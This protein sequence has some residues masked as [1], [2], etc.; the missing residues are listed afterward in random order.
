M[1]GVVGGRVGGR[2]RIGVLKLQRW[3]S[4]GLCEAVMGAK[5]LMTQTSEWTEDDFDKLLLEESL[6]TAEVLSALQPSDFRRH[7]CSL[8]GC[9]VPCG[10]DQSIQ[11][12]VKHCRTG[13]ATIIYIVDCIIHSMI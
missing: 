2:R 6:T 3:F 10:S 12:C 8:H 9:G 4:K 7:T 5:A 11:Y 13:D 1:V